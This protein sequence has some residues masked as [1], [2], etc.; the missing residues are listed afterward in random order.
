MKITRNGVTV[1]LHEDFT[2]FGYQHCMSIKSEELTETGNFTYLCLDEFG[3]KSLERFLKGL[4]DEQK[5]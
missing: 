2:G 5:E 3:Y 4:P 1:D